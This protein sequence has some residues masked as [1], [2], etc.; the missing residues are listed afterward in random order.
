MERARDL[1]SKK[2][3]P[4]YFI[5][6]EAKVFD[7]LKIMADNQVGALVVREA[8]DVVVGII[9]E[10]DYSR[11]VDLRGKRSR[12]TLVKEI[13]T[14]ADHVY[15][16]TPETRVRDCFK[17]M[18]DKHIRHVPVFENGKYVGLISIGDVVRCI[19]SS[20]ELYIDQ[21]SHFIAGR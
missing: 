1:L 16:A 10:R 3:K 8:N 12:E 11:K 19:L 18:E 5:S 21:L 14:P 7:A 6:P 17:L 2:T 4:V 13:M 15:S 20:D 9:S